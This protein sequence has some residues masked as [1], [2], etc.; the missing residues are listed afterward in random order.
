MRRRREQ[1]RAGEA[2]AAAMNASR[3]RFR[4]PTPTSTPIVR[5]AFR[6]LDQA[7]P[8]Y[9]DSDNGY[10][11]YWRHPQPAPV[12]LRVIVPSDNGQQVAVVAGYGRGPSAKGMRLKT[13]IGAISNAP[14]APIEPTHEERR[15]AALWDARQAVGMPHDPEFVRHP[16]VPATDLPPLRGNPDKATADAWGRTWWGAYKQSQAHER[17]QRETDYF[18]DLAKYWFGVRDAMS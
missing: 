6:D 14:L 4:P 7:A 18:K 8:N 10:A 12:G 2:A 15:A 11:Y 3:E 17:P 9:T 16:D 13:V 5:V 1:Q